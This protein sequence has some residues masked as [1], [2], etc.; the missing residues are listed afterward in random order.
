M[1]NL[2]FCYSRY[3]NF[4][5]VHKY[6]FFVI[7]IKNMS[8][9]IN[10]TNIYTFFYLLYNNYRMKKTKTL[11]IKTLLGLILLTTFSI[12]MK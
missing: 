2:G 6:V 12:N 8:T 7:S 10:F 4:P 9:R 1:F 11:K 5:Y 3:L